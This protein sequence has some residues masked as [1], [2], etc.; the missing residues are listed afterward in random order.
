MSYLIGL[1]VY[2]HGN[3]LAMFGFVKGS[4]EIKNQNR[5]LTYED[6]RMSDLIPERDL[7]IMRRQEQVRAENN[8]EELMRQ[9]LINSQRESYHMMQRGLIT[10]STMEATPDGMLDEMFDDGDM[11]MSFFDELNSF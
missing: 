2:Y 3:N 10:N 5:G 7:E 11:N 8:Y 6:I 9:A 4:E 1:Y